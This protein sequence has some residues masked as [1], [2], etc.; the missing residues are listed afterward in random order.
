MVTFRPAQPGDVEAVARVWHDAWHDG[1]DG[2]VPEELQPDRDPAYFR[3]RS[4]DLL[5]HVTVAEGDGE[6]LG[7]LIVL[8]D[9]LQQLMVSAAARGR[10]VGRLLIAEA[11]RQV[12]AAG[13]AEIWL[14]VVPGNETARRFYAAC[15]WSDAGAETYDAKTLAGPTV[16]TPVL[17][18]VKPLLGDRLTG[19]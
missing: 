9:E 17:R 6:L 5:A 14:A 16:S 18:Y 8:D 12:A 19:S 7:V 4:A 10:G 13:Y 15:G 11:E 3:Q 1:H 2:R